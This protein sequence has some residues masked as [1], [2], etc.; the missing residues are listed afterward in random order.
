MVSVKGLVGFLQGYSTK[1]GPG[2]RTTVFCVNCNLRCKWCS[3]P[4]L[5][6]PGKKTMHFTLGGEER[7]Q[8]VG[9][10]WDSAQLAAWLARDRTFYEESGGGVTFS[11]GEAALQEDFVADTAERLLA[12]GISSALDTAGD[13]PWETLDR[14]S[15]RM[16]YVLYD[17]KAFDEE[18]HRR[19]TGRSNVRILANLEKLAAKGQ[20]LIIR[21]VIVPG[22]NDDL[23]DVRRRME[24]VKNLGSTV[25]R[26]DVLPYHTLGKGKYMRLG[27]PYPIAGDERISEIY[28]MQLRAVADEVGVSVRIALE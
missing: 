3:N 20:R 28:W 27:I 15:D 16:E 19:C 11:G 21:M 26:M 22:Y 18:M 4:E 23:V 6:L 17:V 13:V 2:I 5:M 7:T 1:D 12:M 14:L 25:E 24:L 8:E 10:E 9:E